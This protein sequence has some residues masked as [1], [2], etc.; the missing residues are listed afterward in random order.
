MRQ[1]FDPEYNFRTADWGGGYPRPFREIVNKT[2]KSNENDDDSIPISE[3][4]DLSSKA[5]KEAI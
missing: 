4:P 1:M 3:D 5:I 2:W